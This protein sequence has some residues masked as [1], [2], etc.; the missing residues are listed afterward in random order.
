MKDMEI[1]ESCKELVWVNIIFFGV[2]TAVA[3]IG[4]PFY[5]HHYGVSSFGWILAAFYAVASGMSITVGYHRLFAHR[6][7]NAHPVI[8]FLVLFFGAAAFEESALRWASQHRD[9]H[10]YV[11]TDSDPYSIKKGFFYAHIG[12]LI[13]WKHPLN[14]A[15]VPDLQ[16]NKMIMH[17]YRHYHLW[18]VGAGILLPLL[19]GLA[20]GQPGGALILAVC[21][22]L[23][24][25]HHSTFCINSV[26]HMFGKATYD[27]YS[28]AKDHW[29]V[30]LLTF[31]E[32][33]HNFHHRFPSDYRNAVRWYQ[34]DPSK[35]AIYLM[36]SLG[37]AND[38]KRVSTFRILDAK[39]AAQNQRACD[40]I[41]VKVGK[42]HV[43]D[44]RLKLDRYYQEIRHKLLSWEH[45]AQNYHAVISHRIDSSKSEIRRTA[46]LQLKNAREQF[47]EAR[48]Q[49][50]S[51]PARRLGLAF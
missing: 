36:K 18:A 8:Q 49:W 33:Y 29:F 31:G 43:G 13:F 19:I 42:P 28:S 50:E 22:R 21:L 34:W 6:S 17:Q 32:G 41:E 1:K 23:A 11:D 7:F 30:A 24:V 45:A 47:E 15:N 5:I 51:F 4:A 25:V 9:H 3:L 40:W 10:R 2:T 14:L 39:I 48:R 35:W 20:V 26:C 44:V 16:K 12:W 46:V 27:I 38:L 37:L